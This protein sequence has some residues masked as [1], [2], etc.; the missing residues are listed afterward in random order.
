[1]RRPEHKALVEALAGT[2]MF[3]SCRRQDREALA[4]QGR[5]VALP[6]GWTFLHEGTPADACY[7]LLEGRARVRVGSA[8]VASIDAGDVVGEMA[9]V[10]HGLRR[11]S[12]TAD[13]PVRVLR[14]GYD[15]LERLLADRPALR[16]ALDARY[17]SHKVR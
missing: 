5:E 1:M 16:E 7:V 2:T 17:G 10:E 6:A 8:D 15:E 9:L 11:A 13:G 4:D 14:V 12:V 3:G